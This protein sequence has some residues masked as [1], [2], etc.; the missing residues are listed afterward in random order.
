M[1]DIT[2]RVCGASSRDRPF[3]KDKRLVGGLARLCLMCRQVASGRP[4]ASGRWRSNTSETLFESWTADESWLAGLIWADGCL[5]KSRGTFIV[6]IT[7]TDAEIAE[8]VSRISGGAQILTNKPRTPRHKT[9]YAV[10]ISGASVV[11]RLIAIGL[12]QRKSLDLGS[13]LPAAVAARDFLRGYFDGDG[14]VILHLNK[15]IADRTRPAR[16]MAQFNGPSMFLY[17]VQ[18]ELSTIGLPVNQLIRNGPIYRLAYNHKAS[19]LLADYMY[20]DADTYLT[21]K[22]DRFAWGSTRDEEVPTWI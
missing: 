19:L 15:S 4:L 8:H 1:T 22:R 16:L 12:R 13:E 7:T 17:A 18:R 2:C 5:V 21:R 11:E 14:S 3:E 9:P 10:T 20:R 6:T